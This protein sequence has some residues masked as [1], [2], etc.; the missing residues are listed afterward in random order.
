MTGTLSTGTAPTPSEFL[1]T[2]AL[3]ARARER[4]VSLMRRACKEEQLH[5]IALNLFDPIV[6]ARTRGRSNLLPILTN[7][8]RFNT[9]ASGRALVSACL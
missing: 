7:A 4:R 5:S 2:Q 9:H 3:R 1:R 6:H 8:Q